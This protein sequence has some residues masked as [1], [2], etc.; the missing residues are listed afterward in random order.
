MTSMRQQFVSCESLAAAREL[1]PWAVVIVA[2]GEGYRCFE[3]LKDYAAWRD[4]EPA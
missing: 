4:H 3:R 1:C 2:T